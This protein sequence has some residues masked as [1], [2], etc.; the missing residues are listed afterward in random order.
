MAKMQDGL[1]A[2][3]SNKQLRDKLANEGIK[4]LSKYNIEAVTKRYEDLFNKIVN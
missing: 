4:S 1:K 2:L 3:L